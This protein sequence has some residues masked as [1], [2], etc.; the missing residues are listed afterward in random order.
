MIARYANKEIDRVWG[1]ANKLSLWQRTELAV[2]QARAELSLIKPGIFQQISEILCAN[3]IDLDWWLTRDGEIRHDLNAFIDE[4]L[5]HLPMLLQPHF[6]NN[7]TSYDTEEPAFADM[8]NE[9]RLL[10]IVKL[11]ELDMTL[12]RLAKKYRHTIMMAVTHG[13]DAELQ[14]FGKRCLTWLRAILAC[15]ET[16][17]KAGENLKFSKLSG[18]IGNYGSLSPEIE[19]KALDLM[20]L[21]PFYGA[22]QIMPRSLYAPLAEA[23]CQLT[24]E[25]DNIALAI[26]LGARSDKPIYQEPFSKKQKGSSRMPQKKNTISTEQEEGMGRLALGYL[27]AI[28]LNIRTWEERA[29]EQSCVER[30]AWPD[31]FHVTLRSLETIITVLSGLVVYPDNMLSEIVETRGC[32]AAGEA[33]DFLRQEMPA[34]GLGTEAAYRMVQLAA[35]NAFEPEPWA[36]LVRANPAD[37]FESA[38][39]L[40]DQAERMPPPKRELIRE[41]LLKGRLR[42]SS[43]LEATEADIAIWN[44]ALD[45]LFAFDPRKREEF[46]KLFTP[47][48]LLRNEPFLFEKILGQ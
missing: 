24:L 26:R 15:R 12:V 35:F 31:L 18:A 23:L 47:A 41:I 32:Y 16:L 6:H 34:L 8:L 45:K 44:A 29:I 42:V 48:H 38:A 4:R 33:K 43:Q 2:I 22:T 19:A 25:V 27:H 30:V 14:T 28:M 3:P 17:N 13:Q 7:M 36:L 20:S 9:S 10:V 1:N 37:S 39:K 5:R 40:L 21:K 46:S 11:T